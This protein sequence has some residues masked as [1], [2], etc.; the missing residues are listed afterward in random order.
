[1]D[2]IQQVMKELPD[3]ATDAQIKNTAKILDGKYFE[4]MLL[5]PTPGFVRMKKA[6]IRNELQRVLRIPSS[7]VSDAYKSKHT[8]LLLYYYDL[9]CRLRLDQAEAW[10][11][12]NELYED[13]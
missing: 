11:T 4:P 2:F 9:L 5:I 1:M 6:D 7:E 3:D 8:E 10:D 12:I 13:D